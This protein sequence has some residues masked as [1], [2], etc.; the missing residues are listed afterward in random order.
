M[1]QHTSQNPMQA[2]LATNSE[3]SAS[4]IDHPRH[5]DDSAI[6][7]GHPNPQEHASAGSALPQPAVSDRPV[8]V[9]LQLSDRSLLVA[10]PVLASAEGKIGALFYPAAKRPDRDLNTGDG[11]IVGQMHLA[12]DGEAWLDIVKYLHSGYY[13]LLWDNEKGFDLTL[14]ARL[15]VEAEREQL[16]SL[17]KFIRERTYEQAVRVK[18]TRQVIDGEV[19]EFQSRSSEQVYIDCSYRVKVQ[20]GVCPRQT[21][22]DVAKCNKDCDKARGHGKKKFEDKIVYEGLVWKKD[23]SI[24]MDVLKT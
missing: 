11:E 23:I 1:E 19:T 14:Y 5:G 13:P 17:A 24:D 21:H 18:W 9:K 10:R 12:G 4:L 20:N 22:N 7:P 2:S 6:N 15:L 3:H 16:E 8:M